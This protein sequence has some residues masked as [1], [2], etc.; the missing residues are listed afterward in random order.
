MTKKFKLLWW[1]FSVQY[2]LSPVLFCW[3][4]LYAVYDGIS[5]IAYVFVSAKIVSSISAVALANG[6]TS[7]VYRWLGLLL[8]LE[9]LI[10]IMTAINRLL[11]TK[12]NNQVQNKFNEDLMSKMYELSQ[13]QFED[14]AF[15]TKMSR[16]QDGLYSAE[17]TLSEITWMISLMWSL[18]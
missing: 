8:G 3:K 7:S 5:S 9:V 13:E 1:V 15:N 18:R 12:V 2:K 10:K 16:A 6:P 14:E 11:V 17:R 4:F